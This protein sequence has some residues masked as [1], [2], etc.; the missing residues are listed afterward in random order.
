MI[1]RDESKE[2]THEPEPSGPSGPSSSLQQTSSFSEPVMFNLAGLVSLYDA[3]EPVVWP[4]RL[5]ILYARQL[6][7]QHHQS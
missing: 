6:L 7:S 1:E 2:D 3:G 4:D 5:T